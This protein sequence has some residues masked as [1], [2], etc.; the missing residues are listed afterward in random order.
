MVKQ[1]EIFFRVMDGVHG[2]IGEGETS[3][4]FEGEWEGK[5]TKR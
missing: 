1:R 2:E 5:V 4:G 3:Y